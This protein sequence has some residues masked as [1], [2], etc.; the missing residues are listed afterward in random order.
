MPNTFGFFEKRLSQSKS[1]FLVDSGLTYGDLYISS[2]LDYL[3]EKKD[4]ILANFPHLK[5]MDEQ[6]R[7]HPRVAEWLAKRPKT[8]I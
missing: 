6:V 8:D 4:A 1:G 5:K 2:L 3:G 7:A